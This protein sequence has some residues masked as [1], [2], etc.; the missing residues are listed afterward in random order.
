M[1][2]RVFS[3]PVRARRGTRASDWGRIGV[4]MCAYPRGKR[5]RLAHALQLFIASTI[6]LFSFVLG[7]DFS[8]FTICHLSNLQADD[9]DIVVEGFALRE[10]SD[11]GE[12]RG[13]EFLRRKRGVTAG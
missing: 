12:Q 1:L 7:C 13:K 11:L 5:D 2:R 4:C 8:A 3:L 9:A 6:P 10:F